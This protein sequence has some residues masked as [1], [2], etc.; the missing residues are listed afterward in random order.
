MW[1]MNIHK[2]ILQRLLRIYGEVDNA[3]KVAELIVFGK[4]QARHQHHR[5]A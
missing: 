1:S 5:R 2:I 4:R 3:R